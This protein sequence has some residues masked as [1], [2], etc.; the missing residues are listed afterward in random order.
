[1][2][3]KGLYQILTISLSERD[4]I[5]LNRVARGQTLGSSPFVKY[6]LS[7]LEVQKAVLVSLNFQYF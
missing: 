6:F 4:Q 3:G 1:M 2:T 5:T 7:Y